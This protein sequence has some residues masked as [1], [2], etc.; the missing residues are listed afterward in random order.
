ME[1]FRG[2]QVCSDPKKPG[3]PE[4]FQTDTSCPAHCLKD[5]TLNFFENGTG[6]FYIDRKGD[7][8]VNKTEAF[9]VSNLRSVPH[10][11]Y[12]YIEKK[13]G[14]HIL[15]VF[16]FHFQNMTVENY[17]VTYTCDDNVGDEGAWMVYL[18]SCL[19]MKNDSVIFD[20][21]GENN[22]L[23]INLITKTLYTLDN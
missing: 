16:L 7:L 12:I 17:C 5:R 3:Q 23:M 11:Y 10:P 4:H 2:K 21:L 19:C 1:K 8:I 20:Q 13:S 15:L 22:Y 6:D 9:Q 14:F 18:K